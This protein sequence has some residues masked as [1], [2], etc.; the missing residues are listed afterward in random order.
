MDRDIKDLSV[1]FSASNFPPI[2]SRTYIKNVCL[3][4]LLTILSD[5]E[6]VAGLMGLRYSVWFG[7]WKSVWD[8]IWSEWYGER[9]YLPLLLTLRFS[10]WSCSLYSP[11]PH[12]S[13]GKYCAFVLVFSL[14]FPIFLNQIP[15]SWSIVHKN[16]FSFIIMFVSFHLIFPFPAQLLIWRFISPSSSYL[17][18]PKFSFSSCSS[19]ERGNRARLTK[20]YGVSLS[21]HKHVHWAFTS[22]TL[23]LPGRHIILIITFQWITKSLEQTI[24][25]PFSPSG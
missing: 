10:S 14:K 17:N 12:F 21:R 7:G 16:I 1:V 4:F 5:L 11:R 18:F 25:T 2:I 20:C 22:S 8:L 3:C 9:D 19:W 23:S 6:V 15:K 13:C 24:S